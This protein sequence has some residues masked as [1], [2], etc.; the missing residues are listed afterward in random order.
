MNIR[1]ATVLDYDSGDYARL[2][3]DAFGYY[4]E[5]H[6]PGV[7][8]IAEDFG[9]KVGFLTGYWRSRTCFHIYYCGVIRKYA[10]PVRSARLLAEGMKFLNSG[11]YLTVIENSNRPAMFAAIRAGFTPIGTR[12]EGGKCMVEW[13]KGSM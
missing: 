10:N 13:A 4:D 11:S 3:K 6:L 5:D 7:T 8:L 9:E 1:L 12:H 2:F